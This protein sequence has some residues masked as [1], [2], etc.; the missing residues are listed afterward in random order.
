MSDEKT[1]IVE[2]KLEINED[3]ND[4]MG[5]LKAIIDAEDQPGPGHGEVYKRILIKA[6]GL[7]EQGRYDLI[8][9]ALDYV[10]DKYPAPKI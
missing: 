7:R 10:R 1:K 2:S 4:G 9:K 8:L 6:K 5:G 3:P